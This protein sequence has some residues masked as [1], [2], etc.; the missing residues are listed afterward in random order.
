MRNRLVHIDLPGHAHELT[1]SCLRKQPFLLHQKWCAI[2]ADAIVVARDKHSF[3]LWA[4]VFMPS[5]VHLLIRPNK[6]GYS[7][8]AILQAIKQSSSRKILRE[9]RAR[10]VD[11][12]RFATGQ[13]D[14]PL[15]FW[16][17]GPGYDRN[18]TSSK[19]LK[20][21]IMYIHANPVRKGL[22]TLPEE[23]HWSSAVAWQGDRNG[24]LPVDV[25]SIEC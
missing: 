10:N 11:L 8:A 16:Q 14:R 6:P 9:C 1:F 19:A 23:W 2:L 13:K 21:S 7:T 3:S 5:H 22:V 12:S 24:P 4:Y 17:S 25:D 18:V 15:R 20:N